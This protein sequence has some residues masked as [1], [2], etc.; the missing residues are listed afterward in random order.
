VPQPT[1]PSEPHPQPPPRPR[2]VKT[3]ILGLVVLAVV[4]VALKVLGVEHGPSRHGLGTQVLRS[5]E[6][7]VLTQQ[8]TGS[9]L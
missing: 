9:H 5:P 7:P 6:A 2:W 8:G 3:L 4:L 1:V